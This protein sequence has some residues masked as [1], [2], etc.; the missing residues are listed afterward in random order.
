MSVGLL[1]VSLGLAIVVAAALCCYQFLTY[2]A[3]KKAQVDRGLK[4][5]RDQANKHAE[6]V[7]SVRT[8]CLCIVQEQVDLSEG[9]WRVKLHLDHLYPDSS[10]REDFHVFYRMF[11][12]ISGFDT[13]EKRKELGKQERFN[14]DKKRFAIEDRYREEIVSA[15]KKLLSVLDQ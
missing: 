13:H 15:A 10:H 3:L 7:S 6:L 11:D 14:Q 2:Q 5:Q 1:E 9:C 8:L 4:Q 12:E